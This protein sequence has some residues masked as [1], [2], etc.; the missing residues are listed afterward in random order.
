MNEKR[1]TQH[2]GSLIF[3]RARGKPEEGVE[4]EERSAYLNL[5]GAKERRVEQGRCCGGPS[6]DSTKAISCSPADASSP[7]RLF[8][9]YLL[10]RI[11]SPCKSPGLPG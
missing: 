4:K 1:S 11:P 8:H 7:S 9:P 6:R 2:S 3:P 5:K 10:L